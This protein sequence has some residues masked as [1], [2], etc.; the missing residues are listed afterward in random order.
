VSK[1]ILEAF[2][3]M[4]VKLDNVLDVSRTVALYANFHE[5]LLGWIMYYFV[6]I[7]Y[8]LKI[9]ESYMEFHILHSVHYN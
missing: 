9:S 5:I 6:V 2:L 1:L 8:Y 3:F 4:C 7:W